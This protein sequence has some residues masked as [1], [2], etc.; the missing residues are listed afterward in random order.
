MIDA[1]I[2]VYTVGT[3]WKELM[4]YVKVEEAVLGSPSLIILKVSVDVKQ[5]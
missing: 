4:S 3:Q 5:H 1:S 2:Y